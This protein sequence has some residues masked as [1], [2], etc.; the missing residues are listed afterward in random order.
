MEKNAPLYLI[1]VDPQ[2]NENKFY[3]MIPD[4]NCWR[5]EWGR[6]GCSPHISSYPMDVWEEKYQE[7]LKKG[8]EDKTDLYKVR[9]VIVSGVEPDIAAQLKLPEDSGIAELVD[10]LIRY[11]KATIENNYT[12]SPDEVTQEMVDTAQEAIRDLYFS[13]TVQE[14]NNA[15]QELFLIIPRKMSHVKDNIA[16]TI[17]DF[18]KILEREQGLL[19]IMQGQVQSCMAR[20]KAKIECDITNRTLFD[21]MG[22]RIRPIRSHDRE[23]IRRKLGESD[24]KFKNAWRIT[25]IDS[26]KKFDVYLDSH[27]TNGTRPR[28]KLL[29]HGSRSENWFNILGAGLVL[30]PENAVI[31]GKMFGYGIYFAPRARKSIGY[32]SLLGSYWA[33][34]TD[35]TAFLG[36]YAVAVGTPY[37]IFDD[38]PTY[39][40]LEYESFRTMSGGAH[41][42]YAH[43][44][45]TLV[46]DEVVIYREDQC[47]IQYLV[48][49]SD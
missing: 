30:Q 47:T 28:V 22:I 29:W 43:A 21:I 35:S 33:R 40:T 24:S 45:R 42:L 16:G 14:F 3:R 20:H 25:N 8:Y 37:D 5:A 17:R 7:K 19:D 38:D 39:R 48:E 18:K 46:N 13:T 4:K 11:A 6:M 10:R 12:V 23:I 41:C 31:T 9:E 2:N 26:Q 15:L 49:I 44:G 1:K 34:G 36:L 27:K 32:T